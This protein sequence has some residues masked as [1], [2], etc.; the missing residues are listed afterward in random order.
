[1]PPNTSLEGLREIGGYVGRDAPFGDDV[2]QPGG[3]GHMFAHE[4]DGIS[5]EHD[6]VKSRACAIRCERSVKRPH[7]ER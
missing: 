5:Y 4:L 3:A 2:M 7:R 6:G 1:M